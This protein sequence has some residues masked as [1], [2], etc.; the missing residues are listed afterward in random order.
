MQN[1]HFLQLDLL[2]LETKQQIEATFYF[3]AGNVPCFQIKYYQQFGFYLPAELFEK[4]FWLT[5]P[6]PSITSLLSPFIPCLPI[7]E[8][9][10]SYVLACFYENKRELTQAFKFYEEGAKMKDIGCLMK[11]MRIFG[12]VGLADQF[13][14]TSYLL[15]LPSPS[16]ILSPSSYLLPP[17][18]PLLLPP[19]SL[20]PPPSSLPSSL[21]F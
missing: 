14:V 17:L 2:H 6:S 21:Q 10:D 11:M 7:E 19:S 1:F 5:P 16:S 9:K 18:S 12:E 8:C 20:L 15:L 13:N 3:N 4:D